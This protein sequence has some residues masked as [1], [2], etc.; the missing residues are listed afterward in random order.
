MYVYGIIGFT[1]NKLKYMKQLTLQ[2]M[3]KRIKDWSAD[4][5]DNSGSHYFTSG[6]I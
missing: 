1:K 6:T 4:K 3:F 2:D 5:S